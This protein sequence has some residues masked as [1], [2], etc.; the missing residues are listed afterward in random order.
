MADIT[1]VHVAAYR[2]LSPV[3]HSI[4]YTG[5]IW[6]KLEPTCDQG[7][8][9]L[10]V[11]KQACHHRSIDDIHTCQDERIVGRK[12]GLGTQR[13]GGIDLLDRSLKLTH[14]PDNACSCVKAIEDIAGGA[15]S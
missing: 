1:V 8:A 10:L 11:I 7:L 2:L 5:L 12:T 6:V 4:G 15:V 3:H 14:S 9:K 13:L